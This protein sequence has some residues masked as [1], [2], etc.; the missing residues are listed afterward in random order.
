MLMYS[1]DLFFRIDP[2]LL[3]ITQE[4][5]ADNDQFLL[6]LKYAWTKLANMDRYFNMVH[7]TYHTWLQSVSIGGCFDTHV[8]GLSIFVIF[9]LSLQW[10]QS[11]GG[12][13]LSMVWSG[14]LWMMKRVF[15]RCQATHILYPVQT[16][17]TLPSGPFKMYHTTS[18]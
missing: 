1:V 9:L 18:T 16:A 17:E 12:Q 4:F 2:E 6:E 7:A 10:P 11:Y 8:G 15:Y 14:R 3:T 5:A 13:R